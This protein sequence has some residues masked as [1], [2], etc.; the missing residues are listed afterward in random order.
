VSPIV[1]CLREG[2]AVLLDG[3]KRAQAARRLRGFETLLARPI[4]V[5]ERGAKA[6]L[7]ALNQVNRR[8]HEWEEA[9]IIH[10]LVRE[11][12]LSQTEVAELLGR[13]KSWVCRRLALVEK[14]GAAARD[15]LRLGLLSPSMARH[16]VRLSAGNQALALATARRESLT[17]QELSGVV[18]L[19]LS[20]GTREK[21]EFVLQEPRRALREVLLVEGRPWD[22]RLSAAGNRISR[23]LAGLLDDL[24]RLETWLRQR[25]RSELRLCDREILRSAFQRLPPPA[26]AV[27]ELVEDFLQELDLP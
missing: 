17:A 15:D 16:L 23:R 2:R 1:V 8:P 22:P 20:A 27:A 3:F 7:F 25:G 21:Q 4:E 12:G 11:D 14:L 24:S 26:L 5:D 10:A 9:W 18:D 13:H 19:L 6:S